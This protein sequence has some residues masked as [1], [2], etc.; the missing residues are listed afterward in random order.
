L[1]RQRLIAG[2]SAIEDLDRLPAASLD[3]AEV[4]ALHA[5]THAP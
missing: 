2:K 3:S 5:E 1:R 4:R